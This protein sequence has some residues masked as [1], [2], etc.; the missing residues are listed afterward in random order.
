MAV[1]SINLQ[2][3]LQAREA[4]PRWHLDLPEQGQNV[5]SALLNREGLLFQGWVLNES[6]SP[7]ELVVLNGKDVVPLP[8]S[9]SR[10]DVITKVLDEPA[11]KHH[12]LY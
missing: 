9:R 3:E 1:Y 4:F 12:Q 10:P 11:E 6:S 8:F 2:K 7:I 5:D